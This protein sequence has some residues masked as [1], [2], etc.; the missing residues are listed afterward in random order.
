L[1]AIITRTILLA[2]LGAQGLDGG[3]EVTNII[4]IVLDRVVLVRITRS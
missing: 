4:V 2:K 3:D 1:A